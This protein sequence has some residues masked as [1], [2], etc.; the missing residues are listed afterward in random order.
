MTMEQYDTS[1][2]RPLKWLHN[3]APR[4]QSIIKQKANWYNRYH[5]QFWTNWEQTVF[6]IR[7]ANAFGLTIWCIILG[8]PPSLFNFAPIQNAFAYGPER[9]NFIES[10]GY[11]IPMDFV[12]TPVVYANGVVVAAGNYVLSATLGTV[13]FNAAPA[14][15]ASLTWTGTITNAAGTEI[16]VSQPRPFG[17]GD[18]V[19]T[20]FN[21]FPANA[22]DYNTLGANFYGGGSQSVALLSEIRYALQLRYIALVSNGR[23]QWIN[24]MLR[25]IFNKNEEWDS[26][27][28]K[29]FYLTDAT[30]ADEST[31]VLGAPRV[32]VRAVVTK[33]MYMEYRVGPEMNLSAQFIN[34]LNNQEY[35]IMPT[36][37]GVGYAVVQE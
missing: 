23:Q 19:Q 22:S 24:Y 5:N 11:T 3:N 15:N 26:A 30:E 1:I 27:N 29:Y 8:L 33:N 18:G 36:C 31:G 20:V 28:G 6:D 25:Y 32:P 35:G 14:A 2:V 9:D 17:I 34:I 13:T 10:G 21:L 12:T 7:T 37:A 4:L 16:V